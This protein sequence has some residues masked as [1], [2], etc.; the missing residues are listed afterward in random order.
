MDAEGDSLGLVTQFEA[1]PTPEPTTMLL[2]APAV[3]ALLR[4]KRRRAKG[5][6]S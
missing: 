1:V 2:T 6:T 3:A 5:P 4:M